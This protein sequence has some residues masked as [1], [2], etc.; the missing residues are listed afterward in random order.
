MQELFHGE[1]HFFQI[2]WP[3]VI[4]QTGSIRWSRPR[5][6]VAPEWSRPH[7]ELGP[8]WSRPP[9]TRHPFPLRNFY[10]VQWLCQKILWCEKSRISPK[11]WGADFTTA[12]HFQ[13]ADFT[14]V[15]LHHWAEFTCSQTGLAFP[16]NCPEQAEYLGPVF[17][18][19]ITLCLTYILFL[20]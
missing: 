8:Q 7:G 18:A 11:F 3:W 15:R 19:N 13:G 17:R 20:N 2:P 14:S 1:W 6:Q 16:R 4:A 10:G 12:R 5:G 9:P